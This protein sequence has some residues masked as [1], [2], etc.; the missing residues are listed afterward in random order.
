ME[1]VKEIID[2][3]RGKGDEAVKSYT[4]KFDK[5]KL[6]KL[7]VT[8]EDIRQAYNSVSKETISALKF[9]K[10]NIELFAKKQ[11]AQFHDF[12]IN[13]GGVAIGQKVAAIE[14]IGAYVPG[15]N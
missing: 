13:K 3:V 2:D 1:I 4:W 5:V 6:D 9:A 7:M 11:M 12:E 8:E 10:K 15:G 14:K